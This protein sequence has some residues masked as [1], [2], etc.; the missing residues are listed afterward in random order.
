M[1]S[2]RKHSAVTQA[3][4][5]FTLLE[6]LLTV[7][8]VFLFAGAVILGFG[9]LDSNAR[10]EEGASHFE[11]LF[12]YARAQAASTGRQVRIVFDASSALSEASAPGTNSLASVVSTNTG[13]QVLWEADPVDAPGRFEPFPGAQLL[14]EQINDLVKV[15][16]VVLPGA[17]SA[18]LDDLESLVSPPPVQ[19]GTTNDL[20]SIEPVAPSWPSLNCYPDGSSD[21]IQL[22]VAAASGDDKRLAVITLW[23]FSGS[24]ELHLLGSDTNAVWAASGRDQAEPVLA[25]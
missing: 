23:G 17:A 11:T 20:A 2:K 6:L 15:R 14:L 5:A 22:T 25:P 10:L 4:H 12:R 3:R 18:Q 1:A 13:V 21:S 7:A 9:S 24:T 16:D 8:L 19:N